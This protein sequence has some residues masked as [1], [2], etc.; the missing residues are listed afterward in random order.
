VFEWFRN[1]GGPTQSLL[2]SGETLPVTLLLGEEQITLQVTD[3]QGAMST[4]EMIIAVVDGTPPVVVVGLSQSQLWPPNHRLVPISASV[5][6]TDSCDLS[7]SVALVSIASSEP[8]DAPGNGDGKTVE[9]IQDA[10]LGVADFNFTLRAERAGTGGGRLYIVTYAARDASNNATTTTASVP[11]P[12]DQAGVVDPLIITAEETPSGT[13]LRWSEVAGAGSY[14]VVRG[15]VGNLRETETTIDLGETTCIEASSQV[16]NTLGY[17]DPLMPPAEQAFF[18][19]VEYRSRA[20]R[21]SYGSEGVGKPRAARSGG[22][23]LR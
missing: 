3:S 8:D 11:V 20:G 23:Q 16:S 7:P 21:S 15:S 17:E 10:S 19:V 12:H 18:Y 13:L 2:G 6:A 9:D 1:F 14:A 22:C 5:A 4:D